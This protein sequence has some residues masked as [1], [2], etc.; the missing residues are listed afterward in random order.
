[1]VGLLLSTIRC[2]GLAAMKA[3]QHGVGQVNV[4]YTLV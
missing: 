3:I 4:E 2:D 1:M